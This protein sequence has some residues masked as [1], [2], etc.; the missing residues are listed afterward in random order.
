LSKDEPTN[1]ARGSTGS[2]RA[3]CSDIGLGTLRDAHIP[4]DDVA[5]RL[6]ALACS[7]AILATR[8][9][10]ASPRHRSGIDALPPLF[11]WAWERPEDL[12]DLDRGIGV[13]FLAQTITVA[14]DHFRVSP[15]PNR[16]MS[17][18]RPRSLR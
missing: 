8:V 9:P 14:G 6:S 10:S 1:V 4:G 11:I 3:P 15:R 13:A 2:P 16:R 7:V 12:P 18:L 17:P 5:M